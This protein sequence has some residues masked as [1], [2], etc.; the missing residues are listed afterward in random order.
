MVFVFLVMMMANSLLCS[1][2]AA[3]TATA[4]SVLFIKCEIK[5]SRQIWMMDGTLQR[6]RYVLKVSLQ[7]K[8]SLYACEKK[9]DCNSEPVK[10]LAKLCKV[11][12]NS[13][14]YKKLNF[15]FAEL[16][17]EIKKKILCYLLMYLSSNS[18]SSS[19]N[20]R[21]LLLRRDIC[22]VNKCEREFG[23]L[24][25]ETFSFIASLCK[26]WN[27]IYEVRNLRMS[28]FLI[29]YE[30]SEREVTRNSLDYFVKTNKSLKVDF[31]TLE[32]YDCVDIVLY[33][34][35]KNSLYI[36]Y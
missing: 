16:M 12:F 28:D 9:N 19:S 20:D 21:L 27:K 11:Y 29:C 30:K 3:A 34:R 31:L 23:S 15:N 25:I 2:A 10:E 36:N 26:Q 22:S 13:N 8:R 17:K 14:D 4:T 35:D 1:A 33:S 24:F 5:P 32:Q 18:S 6:T 7:N